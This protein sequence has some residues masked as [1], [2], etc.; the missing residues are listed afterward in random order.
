MPQPIK[1]YPPSKL[2]KG[3]PTT[4]QLYTVAETAFILGANTQ[5]VHE[6]ID[7]GLLQALELGNGKLFIRVRG[8]DLE[9]FIDEY[10]R[11]GKISLTKK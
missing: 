9:N 3:L 11:T 6:W 5:L 8:L 4:S 10:I 1:N 2:L 7:G